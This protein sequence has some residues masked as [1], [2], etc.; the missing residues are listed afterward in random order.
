MEVGTAG[1][2]RSEDHDYRAGNAVGFRK[3]LRHKQDGN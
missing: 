3:R 1:R 2:R